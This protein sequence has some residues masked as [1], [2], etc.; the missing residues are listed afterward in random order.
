M[1]RSVMIPSEDGSLRRH[2]LGEPT[3]FERPDGP[4]LS[5][6]PFAAVH[7]VADPLADNTPGTA[8]TIDWDTTLAFRR[9]LWSWGLPVA[10]AMD[11]AQRGMG[12]D[13]A[14]TK[15]L[16]TRS[17]AEAKSVGGAIACGANT[18][19]LPSG[20]ME[21]QRIIDAYGEQIA[22]IEGLGGQAVVMASRHLAAEAV[23]PDAYREAYAAIL[24][25]RLREGDR[26]LAR[27]DVRPLPC[28]VLGIG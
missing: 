1:P 23:G 17:I 8:A 28:R 10:E 24:R 27:G 19:Q 11:T 25:E 26:A 2:T 14:A 21:R 4:L 7:V 22:L 3:R 5:R 20:A 9:H 13:W 12:L 16:I 15:E 6:R 18:D